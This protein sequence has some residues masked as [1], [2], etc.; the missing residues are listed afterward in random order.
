MHVEISFAR[1]DDTFDRAVRLPR[2]PRC[3]AQRGKRRSDIGSA[4][5]ATVVPKRGPQTVTPPAPALRG[6]GQCFRQE[7]DDT[8]VPADESVR[9]QPC[10]LVHAD[11]RVAVWI[12]VMSQ[13][14][15]IDAQHRVFRHDG[16]RG[17]DSQRAAKKSTS[18]HDVDYETVTA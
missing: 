3:C 5:C 10:Q 14:C 17:A 15:S 12:Y 1:Y 4:Q 16:S 18:S 7:R 8:V 6:A 11:F 9:V 2:A 13:R